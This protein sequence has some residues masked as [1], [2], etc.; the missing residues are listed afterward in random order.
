M[1]K[2]RKGE[3]GAFHLRSERIHLCGVSY[4]YP[5]INQVWNKIIILTLPSFGLSKLEDVYR[6]CLESIYQ[7]SL[8]TILKKLLGIDI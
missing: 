4:F 6:R 1:V 2:V 3:S 7:I 5:Y 8:K